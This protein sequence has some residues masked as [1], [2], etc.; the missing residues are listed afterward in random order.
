MPSIAAKEKKHPYFPGIF[1]LNLFLGWSVIGWVIALIWAYTLPKQIII[2]NET[3]SEQINLL[4]QLKESGLLTE[5][6]FNKKK[7]KILNAKK[8]D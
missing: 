6:E 1:I 8:L 2:R 4:A 5:E 3:F 7:A